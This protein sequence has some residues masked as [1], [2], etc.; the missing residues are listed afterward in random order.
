MSLAHGR[1]MV[2]VLPWRLE[3]GSTDGAPF[4]RETGKTV[5]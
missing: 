4:V 2:V 3:E 1:F 5:V